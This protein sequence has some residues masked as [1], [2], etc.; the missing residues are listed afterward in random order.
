MREGREE[1]TGRTSCSIRQDRTA[2]AE[3]PPVTA[4]GTNPSVP[5]AQSFPLPWIRE[6]A[7]LLHRLFSRVEARRK[8]GLSVNESLTPRW[9]G[10][11]YHSAPSIKLRQSRATL[12]RNYYHWL[13][14][15]RTPECLAV[16]FCA[17][18]P[19]I[20]PEVSRGF[21]FACAVPGVTHFSQAFRL[22]DAA[23]LS[24]RRVIASLP[25]QALRTIRTVFAARRQAEKEARGLVRQF[26]RQKYQLLRADTARTAK[27]RRV[28]ALTYRASGGA[29]GVRTP[30]DGQTGLF[31]PA[32]ESSEHSCKERD[33]GITHGG[34]NG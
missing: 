3:K 4:Q 12:R 34:A 31:R 8:Q 24:Y 16:R 15:G 22:I 9:H 2:F 11:H 21:V 25:D 14:H 1:F 7:E 26:Q 32:N 29:E 17:G 5:C 19:A 33:H 6:R 28:A 10:P 20:P 23:G 18:L 30:A 27:L 13:R